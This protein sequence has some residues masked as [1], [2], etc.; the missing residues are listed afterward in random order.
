MLSNAIQ[1][2]KPELLHV[3][4]FSSNGAYATE[5]A[6]Q[7]QLPLVIT[8]SGE[9]FMDDHDIY[10]RSLLLRLALRRGLRRAGAVTA[11]SQYTL[12][13]ALRFGLR[14]GTGSVIYNATTRDE[15]VPNP[16]ATPFERYVL[17]LG[18]VV[19][20]KG[21]DLMIQA[22]AEVAARAP[23]VGL[24]VAGAGS[25]LAAL[26]ALTRQFGVDDRTVF[27]GALS[28]G[29]VAGAVSGASVLVMP[30][31]V[32]AFGIV[33][34][35]GWRGGTPVVV[36]SHGGPREFIRDGLDGLVVDPFDTAALATSVLRVLDD[37]HL[38][39]SLV[40]SGFERLN[41]FT[42]SEVAQQYLGIYRS[43]VG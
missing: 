7:H 14:S 9:T 24:V 30:S 16:F 11:C 17:C 4:C 2:F 26:R 5:A 1:E 35:E 15:I 12:N 38:A 8:L 6:R 39:A 13:D 25:H 43:V 34:L 41:M 42:W 31:R 36:T 23:D 18:R 10:E 27:T 37:E 20:R 3:I 28:R 19:E 21:F 29:A 32:E 22:F 40:S 33:A